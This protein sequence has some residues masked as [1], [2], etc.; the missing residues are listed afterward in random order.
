MD[1]AI[2]KYNAGNV[3]SVLF[4][5]E[6]LGVQATVTDDPVALRAAKRVIFPGVGEAST[7]MRYLREHHLDEVLRSL[8]QPVLGI[9][10]GL[11]LFCQHSEENDVDCLGIFGNVQVRRFPASAGKVPHMGWNR[12]TQ[13]SGPLFH[14]ATEGDYAYFVHSFYAED[15]P[16]ALARCE[17]GLSFSASLQR[18]NFYAVQFHPEK[19][20]ALGQLV[21]RNFLTRC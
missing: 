10:L 20:G 17:Y 21:L 5:L 13:L 2:V 1:L 7:A 15:S 8:T 4:A 19:S 6:R 18:G 14:G 11:Q 16:L 3:Q 12:L 9:C